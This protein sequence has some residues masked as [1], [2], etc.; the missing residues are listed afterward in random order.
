MLV[1]FARVPNLTKIEEVENGMEKDGGGKAEKKGEKEG[2]K[3][4]EIYFKKIK[5]K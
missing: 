2:G 1:D 3:K 5:L 4:G